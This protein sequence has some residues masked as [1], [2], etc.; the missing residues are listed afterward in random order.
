MEIVLLGAGEAFAKTLYQTNFLVRPAEGDPFLVDCGQTAARALHRLGV[1]LRS[2]SAV[3]LSHLHGDHVGG[4]EELGFSA[5]F[6]WGERRDL[7]VPETVLSYLWENGLKAGMGQRLRS[8]GGGFEE[9]GLST[10]FDVHPVLGRQPFCLGSVQ[11]TPF[12]TPH[13]PGRPSWG[14]RLDD[15]VTGG[16]ALLSCDSKFH[17]RNLEQAGAGVQCLFHDCQ[18][19]TGPGLIH[20]T[21]EELLTLPAAWQERTILVHYGDAWRDF[22]G[23]TGPMRFGVEGASY[24]F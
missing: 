10:Y 16:S 19:E 2:V 21:L 22:E 9:A 17:L 5:Y 4:L 20:A 18:L 23:R 15:R 24:R 13:T 11:V 7:W 14:F 1:P 8:P 3:V 12:P 6:Q